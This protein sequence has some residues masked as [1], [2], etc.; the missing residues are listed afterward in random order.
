MQNRLA[1]DFFELPSKCVLWTPVL[2][3]DHH[4][5]IRLNG[6]IGIDENG[7]AFAEEGPHGVVSCLH[8]KGTLPWNVCFKHRVSMDE[9]RKLFPDCRILWQLVDQDVGNRAH[10]NSD[11][12]S[13]F[14]FIQL[15]TELSMGKRRGIS[16]TPFPCR[17]PKLQPNR[18]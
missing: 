3:L 11:C 2:T 12:G 10:R 7:L 5:M 9:T 4:I 16:S 13:Q 18:R 17:N 14:L 8:G 1:D 15:F 6:K